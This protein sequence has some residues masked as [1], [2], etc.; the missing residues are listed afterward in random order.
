MA[1]SRPAQ[2]FERSSLKL[3]EIIV[4]NFIG[5]AFWA[6]GATI[7][8][9]VIITVLTLIVQN[10]DFNLIPVVGEFVSNVVDFVMN[11]NP[12]FRKAN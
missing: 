2:P 7:G 1:K 6:L 4:N 9:A 5:G 11:N 8:L 3:P 12:N 10:V